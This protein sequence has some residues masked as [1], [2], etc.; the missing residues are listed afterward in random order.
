[1]ENISACACFLNV[2]TWYIAYTDHIVISSTQTFVHSQIS[3][4]THIYTKFFVFCFFS[5]EE[6]NQYRI[7]LKHV[8]M[9]LKKCLFVPSA[10]SQTVKKADR[11]S[12]HFC[13]RFKEY[14][15]QQRGSLNQKAHEST[16]NLLSPIFT[17]QQITDIV[18]GCELKNQ[19]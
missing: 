13:D 10:S 1:M 19:M 2:Y 12:C 7:E 14:N 17:L 6:E 16:Q 18:F 3:S 15:G 4:F 11:Y 5:Q 9:L 8:G